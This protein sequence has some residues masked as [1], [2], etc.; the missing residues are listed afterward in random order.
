M[1]W[2]KRKRKDYNVLVVAESK[3]A[4]QELVDHYLRHLERP[5]VLSHI[6]N[7]RSAIYRIRNFAEVD[8][9]IKTGFVFKIDLKMMYIPE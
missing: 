1:S 2:K 5:Y 7:A 3:N 6:P 8:S 9:R 4:R